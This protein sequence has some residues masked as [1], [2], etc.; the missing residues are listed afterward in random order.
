MNF[1]DDG[2]DAE[3]L[4]NGLLVPVISP[5]VTFFLWGWAKE[6][7][8]SRSP[9]TLEELEHAIHDVL[10]NIPAEFL[11]KSLMNEVPDRLRKLID[12]NGGY[13]EI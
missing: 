6:Q 11:K 5:H 9:S 13:V 2:S 3:G 8:Y 12:Q 4:S 1:Q 10:T 7:V